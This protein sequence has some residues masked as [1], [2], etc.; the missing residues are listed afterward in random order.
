[1][2]SFAAAVI[3]ATKTRQPSEDDRLRC[4][5]SRHVSVIVFDIV[6]RDCDLVNLVNVLRLRAITWYTSFAAQAAPVQVLRRVGE[7]SSLLGP[8]RS[9]A[10]LRKEN[11]NRKV[12]ENIP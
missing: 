5:S 2:A 6:S 11:E 10:N 3:F 1:M 7:P 8:Q 12:T 9:L 4:P